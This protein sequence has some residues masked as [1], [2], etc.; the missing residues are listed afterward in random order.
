[1]AQGAHRT[2]AH[3]VYTDT[4]NTKPKQQNPVYL[5]PSSSGTASNG[6]SGY[7]NQVPQVSSLW[8]NGGGGGGATPTPTATS[9]NYT[10][11]NSCFLPLP[12]LPPPLKNNVSVV[13]LVGHNVCAS[14]ADRRKVCQNDGSVVQS[15][16]HMV[17]QVTPLVHSRDL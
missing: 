5:P 10:G 15:L 13:R 2:C 11:C 3:K 16:L 6:M 17:L 9:A 12:K 4:Q 1:M 8:T 14:K 7:E